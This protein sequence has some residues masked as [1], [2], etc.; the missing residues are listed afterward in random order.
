MTTYGADAISGVVNF[1]TRRDFAGIE[2]SASRA[3]HRA[4]AT[5]TSSAP[6]SPWA[7]TSTTAAATRSSASATRN[8]TRSIRAPATSRVVQIS[9][10]TGGAGGSGT[11][12]PSRFT[13]TRDINNATCALVANDPA[14]GNQG[15]SQIN[16][17]G[18]PSTGCLGGA[19]TG[20]YSSFNF[21]PYNIFQTPFKRY[22]IFGQAHYEV[23]RRIEV[24]ARG[25]FSKNKVKTIIAPSGSFGGSVTDHLSNPFLPA[26]AAQPVLRV[27]RRLRPAL[28]VYTPRF[29]QA[30]CAA[31]ATATGPTDP[32][33]RAVT[34]DSRPPY[35]VKSVRVSASST[36][37]MFDYRV[38]ACAVRM[39]RH[40]RLGR[41]RAPTAN[42]R[43]PRRSRANLTRCSRRFRPARPSHLGTAAVPI[44]RSE[45]ANLPAC[46]DDGCVPVNIFGPEG[47]ITPEMVDFLNEDS[48][49]RARPTLGQRAA[50]DRGDFGYSLPWATQPIGF[51]V[52]T[53]FRKYKA[54]QSADTLA[55]T[56][57]ELG[58]AGGAAPDINGGYAVYE[59]YAEFIA[60]IIED[61]PVLREPDP[62]GRH[63]L[64]EV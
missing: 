34:T 38:P 54:K 26:G 24:Y 11:A 57:G 33:Y 21:N 59:G 15:S 56:P 62:R 20:L 3:D 35:D 51:A 40:D 48:T 2:V 37:P 23:S 39:T 45:P 17:G 44:R 31:A 41:R 9:S 47:S 12:V 52:G 29:T 64:L 25:L 58:G 18:D 49:T 32:N 30:E 5:A 6:T 36:R 10:Y 46:R 19:A 27:R 8:R 43:T 22:N 4:R 60:P 28:A 7:P 42:P 61:K 50:S 16:W 13:G 63:P 55:K 14:L 1:I 53:E